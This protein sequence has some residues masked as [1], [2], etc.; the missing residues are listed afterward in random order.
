M[1][2]REALAK[3]V[4]ASSLGLFRILF[5][6]LMTFEMVNYAWLGYPEDFWSGPKF[7]FKHAFFEWLPQFSTPVYY[8]ILGL[9]AVAA[10]GM[11]VGFYYRWCTALF[12]VGYTYLTCLEKASYNNHF[13]L[14]CL[15]GLLMTVVGAHHWRS[16]DASRLDLPVTIP[17]WHVYLLQFQLVVVYFYG[18]LSKVNPDW[19]AGEPLRSAYAGTALGSEFVVHLLAY[20]GLFFDFLIGYLL[21]WQ[22]T[23]AVALAAA[24]GFHFT[25]SR[26]FEIGVFPFLGMGSLVIFLEP[27]T[28]ARW[29]KEEVE[30]E[31]GPVRPLA[32]LPLVALVLYGIIQIGAPLRHWLYPGDVAW[33]EEGHRYAWRMKL[34]A[35]PGS[36][37]VK[38]VDPE[39]GEMSEVNL[40][41][42]LTYEQVK[43]LPGQPDM[44]FQL[45]HFLN[46][47]DGAAYRVVSMVG[48]NGRPY[49]LILDPNVD[50]GRAEYRPF[51][52]T[53]WILPDPTSRFPVHPWVVPSLLLGLTLV[54]V[55]SVVW[56]RAGPA[57]VAAEVA[58]AIAFWGGW[59]PVAVAGALVLV[60]LS[61]V[62]KK[63]PLYGLLRFTVFCL[64]VVL[65]PL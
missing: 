4:H 64:G 62:R 35:K 50:L 65:L 49:E 51:Q 6:L 59:V 46:Q 61:L 7:T 43:V 15:L 13:Y 8:A 56:V 48:L 20:G 52:P 53:E 21:L 33:T 19:L 18:G 12:T 23:R 41:R 5:G 30:T 38:R 28:P 36:V 3:P 39:T 34:R 47:Q 40:G 10:V 31:S 45:A 60:G 29:L 25:N 1:A 2:L 22:P 32:I 58:V 57:W 37:S 54:T 24:L 63:D 11:T 14:I 27:E 44:L 42:Y 55:L 9:L 16:Y 17:A 26:L